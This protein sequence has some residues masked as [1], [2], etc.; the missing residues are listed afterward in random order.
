[1]GARAAL[2]PRVQATTRTG[3]TLRATPE[4]QQIDRV[5]ASPR[6]AR[7]RVAAGDG[8]PTSPVPRQTPQRAR[9]RPHA[10]RVQLEEK[11]EPVGDLKRSGRPLEPATKDRINP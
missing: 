7:V 8:L 3:R 2:R 1:V 5:G 4:D 9:L 11:P 10:D 6:R